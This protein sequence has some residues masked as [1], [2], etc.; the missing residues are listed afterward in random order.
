MARTHIATVIALCVGVGM[1]YRLSTFSRAVEDVYKGEPW[2][3]EGFVSSKLMVST[4]FGRC[5]LHTLRTESGRVMSDWLWFDDT[6]AVNVLVET[7]GG[8]FLVF[9]QRKYG[10]PQMTHAVIGGIIEKGETP[11]AAAQ[12]ELA[13]ELSMRSEKWVDLGTYRTAANR[14]GGYISWF[15]AVGARST[16]T[17]HS[18]DDLETRSVVKLTRAQLITRLLNKEFG[19]IKWAA[20]VAMALLYIENEGASASAIE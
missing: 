20:T 2:R 16:K 19:E 13:E 12:R 7:Q 17:G 10:I 4:K 18:D 8:D 1:V 15:L 6:D 5:E 11:L 14:G 3:P 9:R